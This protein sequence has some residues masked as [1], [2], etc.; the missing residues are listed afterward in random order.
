MWGMI[1]NGIQAACL[2]HDGIKST[3]WDAH[4]IGYLIVFTA[5][6][7]ILYCELPASTEYESSLTLVTAIAPLLY[8]MASS[9]YFNISILTSDFYGLI[10]GENTSIFVEL[11]S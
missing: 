4:V 9:T 10:F 11:F 5:S 7:F 1:I 8:R 6:M 2:E 3:N